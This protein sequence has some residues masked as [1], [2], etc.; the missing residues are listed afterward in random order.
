MMRKTIK[1]LAHPNFIVGPLDSA[2][3]STTSISYT[4]DV[5]GPRCEEYIQDG[6]DMWKSDWKEEGHDYDFHICPGCQKTNCNKCHEEL[7][8]D[9]GQCSNKICKNHEFCSECNEPYFENM[10]SDA[11]C[12]NPDC[13][14]SGGDTTPKLATKNY[15]IQCDGP[16]HN[17][18]KYQ[19]QNGNWHHVK[20][21]EASDEIK[22][23][24]TYERYCDSDG[25][26]PEYDRMPEGW[27]RYENDRNGNHSTDYCSDCWDKV[28]H[29]CNEPLNEFGVCK[30]NN[31][32]MKD[33]CKDCEDWVNEQGHCLD[34]DN[35]C[36][37]SAYCHQCGN[38]LTPDHDCINNDCKTYH[39]PYSSFLE[40]LK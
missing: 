39:N 20:I 36:G 7:N 5:R 25:W 26:D 34:S 19:N 13:E 17:S 16:G 27:H 30:N 37:R 21:D 3:Y 10:Y 15:W 40:E 31:C 28:C 33:R 35:W 4:C 14:N 12:M 2:V 24:P 38:E 23:N 32:D 29:E 11:Y 8:P 9:T 22:N 1:K 6:D 18:A